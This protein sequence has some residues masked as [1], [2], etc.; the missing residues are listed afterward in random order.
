MLM[1]KSSFM[2]ISWETTI[3]SLVLTDPLHKVVHR[4]PSTSLVD[5]TRDFHNKKRHRRL[6]QRLALRKVQASLCIFFL[7][8][9]TYFSQG[10]F[11]GA[12]IQLYY[13]KV[14]QLN[15]MFRQVNMDQLEDDHSTHVE[16]I[17]F[18]IVT[19][20]YK[21]VRKCKSE[22]LM[23]SMLQMSMDSNSHI[24]RT[25]FAPLIKTGLMF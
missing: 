13:S 9:S 19:I 15:S 1:I 23:K 6:I 7:D 5:G 8:I 4:V 21:K 2:L 25:S 22:V 10:V 20:W 24:S 14:I 17:R 12:G 3:G 16:P 11:R 18:P